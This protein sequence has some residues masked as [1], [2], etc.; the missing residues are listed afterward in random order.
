MSETQARLSEIAPTIQNW[1]SINREAD[2]SVEQIEKALNFW[3][4]RSLDGLIDECL[5]HCVAGSAVHAV[6]RHDFQLALHDGVKS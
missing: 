6:G 3:L 1:L 2:Y 4:E 5:Y